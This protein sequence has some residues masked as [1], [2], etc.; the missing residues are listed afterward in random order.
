MIPIFLKN[1]NTKPAYCELNPF[2]NV[3]FARAIYGNGF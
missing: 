3:N 2:I 1:K